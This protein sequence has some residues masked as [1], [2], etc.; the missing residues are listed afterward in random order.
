MENDDGAKNEGE[1]QTKDSLPAELRK[2]TNRAAILE[3]ML[4][5]KVQQVSTYVVFNLHNELSVSIITYQ[6]PTAQDYD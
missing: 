1:V 5:K 2:Y 6:G 4:E 3:N